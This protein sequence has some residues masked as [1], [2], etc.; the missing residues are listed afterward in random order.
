MDTR[1]QNALRQ[2]EDQPPD[3]PTHTDDK[4]TRTRPSLAERL[5]NGGITTRFNA[6][7]QQQPTDEQPNLERN[8]GQEPVR[9]PNQ[10]DPITAI[11]PSDHPR[12]VRGEPEPLNQPAPPIPEKRGRGRPRKVQTLPQQMTTPPQQTTTEQ[13]KPGPGRSRKVQIPQPQARNTTPHIQPDGTNTSGG[14]RPTTAGR[15]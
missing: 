11:Q 3:P 6:D 2:R 1:R 12:E 15:A 7:T 4:T 5:N 9:E 13:P 14:A 10:T 8:A